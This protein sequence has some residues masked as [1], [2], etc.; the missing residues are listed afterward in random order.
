MNPLL[1]L[2][3]WE[4][5][6]TVI[7]VTAV[8]VAMYARGS[9][10]RRPGRSRQLAFWTGLA[11]IYIGLH[12]RLDYYAEREFFVHRFQH[13]LLHHVGPFLIALSYPGTTLRA[14]VPLRWRTRWLQPLLRTWPVRTL[15]AVLFNPWVAS[16]LF[17]GVIY[18]WLWPPIH[19]VAML[20][21][22]LYRLMNWSVTVDGL[23][24]WWLVMD[25]RPRPPARLGPG[26]RVL[27]PLFVAVPQI[28]LGAFISLAKTDLYPIYALCGRAFPSISTMSA[29][30]IGGLI[31]WIPSAMMSVL[32]S[33]IAMGH[34]MSL[35]QRQ[36]LPRQQAYRRSQRGL[37][38]LPADGRNGQG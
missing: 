17:F 15:F 5:S 32:A 22:R 10:R 16:C 7:V 1:W 6:P 30:L 2:D 13:L 24:F 25:P 19:F 27:V 31:L 29:Q 35:S 18:V 33:L 14:A 34:W 21:W 9:R 4:F 37:P 26:M 38:P 28:L 20:D 8:A 36:R 11:L 12:T 23:L 3:P